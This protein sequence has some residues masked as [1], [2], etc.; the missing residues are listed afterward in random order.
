MQR[1]VF[2]M[3]TLILA[4]WF[5]AGL[6]LAQN[7]PVTAVDAVTTTSF[8]PC[9]DGDNCYQLLESLPWGEDQW[10]TGLN[11]GS[12]PSEGSTLGDFIN[13]LF[14][15]GI[16]IA[17][18]LAVV[19]LTIYGFQ[20]ASG[21]TTNIANLAA[22][23]VK[24]TNVVIGLLLLLSTFVILNTINPDLTLVEPDV[25]TL[26]LDLD[27]L[28][29]DPNVS[30]VSYGSSGG[31]GTTAFSLPP[32]P[33]VFCPNP[34]T[35]DKSLIPKIVKSFE[36]KTT[37]RYGG[38]GGPAPGFS[39]E[40]TGASCPT[41]TICLDCSGFVN[42]V[43]RCAGLASPGGGTSSIFSGSSRI[44]S[45]VIQGTRVIVNNRELTSGDLIGS[46]G[47]HVFLYVGGGVFAD[48]TADLN[49]RNP[50]K[51]LAVGDAK[52]IESYVKR[53]GGYIKWAP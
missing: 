40:D 4:T 14:Q 19:M 3:M 25:A 22:L 9:T 36:K 27:A 6:V 39:G 7:N 31:G 44:T 45:F 33:A 49:G 52:R 15:L 51:G 38:K 23:K 34:A 18:V 42:H 32:S 29:G 1:I 28:E 12:E 5:S 46:P 35:A 13:L 48:Q 20:Y 53:K 47:S 24:I 50:G 37:Y 41:D 10:I 8:T 30:S 21:D 2:G 43:Y 11:V 26:T 17:G 16:G